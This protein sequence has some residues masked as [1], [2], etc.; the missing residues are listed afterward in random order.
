MILSNLERLMLLVPSQHA[1]NFDTIDDEHFSHESVRLTRF[2][3]RFILACSAKQKVT[4]PES[5][6]L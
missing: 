6:S 5:P 1:S 4:A 3:A 2:G